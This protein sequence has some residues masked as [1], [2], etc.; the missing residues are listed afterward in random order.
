MLRAKSRHQSGPDVCFLPQ[1]KSSRKLATVLPHFRYVRIR[2]CPVKGN[3]EGTYLPWQFCSAARCCESSA[4]SRSPPADGRQ[5]GASDCLQIQTFPGS[6]PAFSL[7]GKWKSLTFQ[8]QGVMV[9]HS[10]LA[11]SSTG[12]TKHHHKLHLP[13]SYAPASRPSDSVQEC[14]H[15]CRAL[16]LWPNG[17]CCRAICLSVEN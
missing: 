9:G 14:A 7:P 12:S 17:N 10:A 16:L 15:D 2:T 11:Q 4:V 1:Q 5:A 8:G 3:L 6:A 13:N